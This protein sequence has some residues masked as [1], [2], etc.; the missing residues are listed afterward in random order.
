[1][2]VI[3]SLCEDIGYKK[4]DL[5]FPLV[6]HPSKENQFGE[7]IGFDVHIPLSETLVNPSQ[8]LEVPADITNDRALD[9]DDI[10]A[11]NYDGEAPGVVNPDQESEFDRL[12]INDDRVVEN[13][14][15]D[16][17]EEINLWM[18]QPLMKRPPSCFQ[19]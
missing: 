17:D 10:L 7:N 2:S 3:N 19:R 13:V 18:L 6:S 12:S 16:I 5:P 9:D 1:M 8:P 11:E 15:N 4:S 14:F